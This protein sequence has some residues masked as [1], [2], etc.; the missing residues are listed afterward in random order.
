MKNE[1]VASENDWTGLTSYYRDE[2]GNRF[3]VGIHDLPKFQKESENAGR[4]VEKIPT[5]KYQDRQGNEFIVPEDRVRDFFYENAANKRDVAEVQEWE[6]KSGEQ[7]TI[8]LWKD[9]QAAQESMRKAGF[10][11]AQEWTAD[12]GYRF[13]DLS[14]AVRHAFSHAE[15]WGLVRNEDG[16]VDVADTA[17]EVGGRLGRGV[18][19]GAASIAEGLGFGL[20]KMPVYMAG[21]QGRALGSV[22]KLAGADDLADKLTGWQA[23]A[24]GALENAQEKTRNWV[25][26]NVLGEAITQGGGLGRD[27]AGA[28][29]GAGETYGDMRLALGALGRLGKAAI[30]MAFGAQA[31]EGTLEDPAIQQ[32]GA[33]GSAVAVV[34]GVANAL[35]M[36]AFGKLMHAYAL[37]GAA[38]EMQKTFGKALAIAFGE[39]VAA[40]LDMGAIE[41]ANQ[42]AR[43]IAGVEDTPVDGEGTTSVQ[44]QEMRTATNGE[45][46]GRAMSALLHGTIM[47]LGLKAAELSPRIAYSGRGMTRAVSFDVENA[48]REYAPKVTRVAEAARALQTHGEAIPK[49]PWFDDVNGVSTNGEVVFKDGTVY[50]PAKADRNVTV[51]GADGKPSIATVKGREARIVVSDGTILN[52]KGEVVGKL[53]GGQR[54]ARTV[55]TQAEAYARATD[56][57][58]SGNEITIFDRNTG[59]AA[60]I[61]A[62]ILDLAPDSYKAYNKWLLAGNTFKAPELDADG[63]AFGRIVGHFRMGGDAKHAAEMALGDV[64]NGRKTMREAADLLDQ[65]ERQMRG[66]GER[67]VPSTNSGDTADER[68]SGVVTPTNGEIK[69]ETTPRANGELPRETV[70]A[71]ADL[72]ELGKL[73]VIKTEDV[74]VT[75]IE[76]SPTDG[77]GVQDG[78]PV[79][80]TP[81]EHAPIVLRL[82]PETGRLEPVDGK[83]RIAA[84]KANGAKTVKA[85]V[86]HE[87]DG[88]TPEN[89]EAVKLVGNITSGN[90]DAKGMVDA[91]GK[92]GVDVDTAT[93]KGLIG[94]GGTVEQQLANN[95]KKAALNVAM[96]GDGQ[97]KAVVTDGNLM[98]ISDIVG[99]INKRT[100]GEGW[101]LAQR[102]AFY[103]LDGLDIT[104]RSRALEMMRT[105]QPFVQ[106]GEINWRELG[107]TAR[108]YAKH[109]EELKAEGISVS[110]LPGF[111]LVASKMSEDTLSRMPVETKDGKITTVGEVEAKQPHEKPDVP[112]VGSAFDPPEKLPGL[113]LQA[114]DGEL[115]VNVF[116]CSR[117]PDMKVSANG[118]MYSIEG[119]RPEDLMDPRNRNDYARVFGEIFEKAAEANEQLKA[120]WEKNGHRDANGQATEEPPKVL[121]NFPPQCEKQIGF[122]LDWY[123]HSV[124]V[125][126]KMQTRANAVLGILEKS[127]LASGVVKDQEAFDAALK[128]GGY[129][130][131]VADGLTYGWTDGTNVYLNPK[132]FGTRAGLNTPIHE[133]G[134]LGIIA[135]KKV[136]RALYDRGIELVKQTKE[137]KDINDPNG[138]YKDYQK[139]SDEKKA[140]EILTRF[141]AKG[142]EGIDAATPKGVVAEIKK[143]VAAFWESLGKRIGIRDLTPEQ[144]AKMATV[145]DVADAIRAEMMTGREFGTRELSLQE[146]DLKAK[147][148]RFAKYSKPTSKSAKAA[149][150]AAKKA[151]KELSEEQKVALGRYG[152]TSVLKTQEARTIANGV[153]MLREWD[154][155]RARISQAVKDQIR[156]SPNEGQK[157]IITGSPQYYV[158]QVT[159]DVTSPFA[160]AIDRGLPIPRKGDWGWDAWDRLT[161]GMKYPEKR[162]LMRILGGEHPKR[163]G[164]DTVL[165][166]YAQWL[167]ISWGEGARDFEHGRGI[168]DFLDDIMKERAKFEQWKSGDRKTREEYEA[169]RASTDDLAKVYDAIANGEPPMGLRPQNKKD[170]AI[171]MSKMAELSR[172]GKLPESV[173][174]FDTGANQK[175]Y[176]KFTYGDGSEFKIYGDAKSITAWAEKVGLRRTASVRQQESGM[177]DAEFAEEDAWVRASEARRVEAERMGE[178]DDLSDMPDFSRA[179]IGGAETAITEGYPLSI[180]EARDPN[181]VLPK[182]S[183][184]VGRSA[185]QIGELKL[186]RITEESLDHLLDSPSSRYQKNSNSKAGKKLWRGTVAGMTVVDD[187]VA[188]SSLGQQGLP[189]HLNREWKKKAKFYTADTRFAVELENGKY[190]VY[191]CK[192]IVSEI[193]GERIVYDLTEIGEPTLTASGSLKN[194]PLAPGVNATAGTPGSTRTAVSANPTPRSV[195]N[196]STNG[197][198]DIMLSRGGLYTGSAAD[199]EKPSL[200]KVGTGEGSQ[201]Y[202]WGLYASDRR[203]VAEEYANSERIKNANNNTNKI[204]AEVDKILRKK[205]KSQ[206]QIDDI[207]EAL[208]TTER[209]DDVKTNLI[210]GSFDEG[211]FDVFIKHEKEFKKI[212]DELVAHRNL[213]EQTFFTNRAPGDES[214]LLKWYEPVTREQMGW[215]RN[216]AE[217]EG[218]LDDRFKK[219]LD[220][221]EKRINGEVGDKANGESLYLHAKWALGTPQAASEF[222]ARAGIDG[223]KYPVDS[224]GKTVKDG[225]K[226]GWNYVSFRDDNIRVDHKWRDG[227]MLFSRPTGVD[228][229]LLVFG[230]TRVA[231]DA[232]RGEQTPGALAASRELS[233]QQRTPIQQAGQVRKLSLQLSD[234]EFARKFLTGSV[235]P[236]HIAKRLP[237]GAN[238]ASTKS[239]KLVIAADLFGI[240]DKT[241]HDVNKNFLK[242][243]GYFRNEDLGWC[244]GKTGMQIAAER[245]RS[246]EQLS[247]QLDALRQRRVNGQEPGGESAARAIFADELANI[248]M[249]MRHVPTGGTVG[250]VRTIGDGLRAGLLAR[251]TPDAI[252]D[253]AGAFLDWAYGAP[254]AGQTATRDLPAEQLTNRMFGAYLVMPNEIEARAPQWSREIND[255]IASDHKL[256]ETWR[257]LS[258]RA[259][260]EQSFGAVERQMLAALDR[261][262]EVLIRQMEAD[263]KK[264]ISAGSMKADAKEQL[265]VGFH[266]RMAPVAVRIDEKVKT[267]RA[268]KKE[269]MKLARTPQEKQRLASELSRFIG[270]VD[271]AVN[272][273]KLSRLAFERGASGEGM[274]YFIKEKLLL[275][276]L[277]ERQG[278]TLT[279]FALYLDHQRGIETQ[280]RANSG[281]M[282]PRQNKLALENMKLRLGSAKYHALEVGA[283]KWFAIH[284]QEFLDDPRL[285]KACG[286]EYVDYLKTQTHYV[287][288]A[289]TWSP[290]ELAGIEQGR[291]AARRSGVAGGDD[292]LESMFKFASRNGMGTGEGL[293][294]ARLTGSFADKKNVI[295]ATMDKVDRS[296]KFLRRN[297]YVM[298]LRDAL[299][300]AGVEGVRDVARGNNGFPTGQRYGHLNYLENGHKRTL[301]VPKQIAD[302]FIHD[303]SS[304][305]LYSKFYATWRKSI[306]DWNLAYW[307]RNIARNS[308]SI[309]KNMPGVRESYVKTALRPFGLGNFADTVC[310][311][312]VRHAPSASRLFGDDT[313]FGLIPKAKRIA[314]IRE[315]PS[316]WEQ[317]LWRAIDAGDVEA[318]ATLRGDLEELYR[319]LKTN[320]LAPVRGAYEGKDV[321]F[322]DDVLGQKSLKTIQRIRE[323]AANRTGGQKAL[324]AATWVFRRASQQQ[325]F[326]DDLAKITAYLHD[327]AKFG[328]VRTEKE[329]GLLVAE[330]V[331]IAQSER[332]GTLKRGIQGTI[333]T[334]YN[335]VEKGLVRNVK[336]HIARPGEMFAKDAKV[337][338]GTLVGGLLTT[339][340]ISWAIRKMFDDDES[341]IAESPFALPYQYAEFW[342]K[343]SKNRSTYMKENCNCV[344]VWMSPSGKTT[345]DIR[346]PY[347]DEDKL[348]VPGAQFAAEMIAA[349]CGI[350][351]EPSVMNMVK[352]STLNAITPDL[353][354]SG[355]L[356]MLLRDTVW[357]LFTNPEDYFT[358]RELYDKDLHENRFESLE[359]GGKFAA[360]MGLQLWNDL[361]GR[362]IY[363]PDRSGI[364]GERSEV[365]PYL[366]VVL[367]K[368]PIASPFVKSFLSVQTGDLDKY[369]KPLTEAEQKRASLL[370][371]LRKEAKKESTPEV[372]WFM[373]DSEGY[374]KQIDKWTETYKLTPDELEDLRNGISK[375]WLEMGPLESVNDIKKK[376]SIHDKARK[377]GIDPRYITD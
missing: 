244:A 368:L 294:T 232:G 132:Y 20:A 113:D 117:F 162:E 252:R 263:A 281:G 19:A 353:A 309:E 366:D 70:E 173:E 183:G 115:G 62:N 120:E 131:L 255:I 78:T 210:E 235:V 230:Q 253:E 10:K 271:D 212:H 331:S 301:I 99:K 310:Q 161:D 122:L 97:L 118:G 154:A 273:M 30:P 76:T 192:L 74:D 145:E 114:K 284:E 208:D 337:W 52:A 330:N 128:A 286:K 222:L 80:P 170:A 140:E 87:E 5:L 135:T 91:F 261:Q 328:G 204:Y 18:L 213:Y 110:G 290:E 47:T 247:N 270:S 259:M 25:I 332:S 188:T 75:Q 139:D 267:Y 130:E 150:E 300:A 100:W 37:K 257:Q 200:L 249:E 231:E 216:A 306:I 241:D 225:D 214:H 153:R 375:D 109:Y 22:A 207:Y 358:G 184:I 65:V 312:L 57:N 344:P 295:A 41:G 201:V 31:V 280:G 137:W 191:P 374:Q 362:V 23:G 14:N 355:P 279:D 163:G 39:S 307:N 40:G 4:K 141:I 264:P 343:A 69:V 197:K 359:M 243:N 77:A 121:V 305:R 317:Q 373:R 93:E 24:Y 342:R 172:D 349:K 339:G 315:D 35:G 248:V 174:A 63:L 302:G 164:M 318:E 86:L 49:G 221:A 299:L 56:P 377:Q 311:H 250:A 348:I 319:I 155:R 134:H 289:R 167:G 33:A 209:W 234:M 123:E 6:N 326:E 251:G 95:M 71:A 45:R 325:M 111:D 2:E 361:G 108:Y 269:A 333:A 28:G 55:D 327:R 151:W 82:N 360:A 38:K 262:T 178:Q 256:L 283:R 171:A 16:S 285:L 277:T 34:N 316:R 278:L 126:P 64:A 346:M 274:V 180:R 345:L 189:K 370:R 287:T 303:Q 11:P 168:E 96:W 313:I 298:D 169:E 61:P 98:A 186:T 365:S 8:T 203:G 297:Q 296:L 136:N 233:T 219:F 369:A 29:M 127:G 265:L 88:W 156:R 116:G 13:K 199:Y 44:Q 322:V 92:L 335:M 268:A 226:A 242:Q 83:K 138:P 26:D 124:K 144:I 32:A 356:W 1:V 143:W 103:E 293:L 363:Q 240:I 152:D 376:M 68:E 3:A 323:E 102:A 372:S 357:S 206:Q 27:L 160:Y 177:T 198:G 166:D 147:I 7:M 17:K 324:D 119:V 159:G 238:S 224:Y 190:E 215:V 266:D 125:D 211:S 292:V 148:L 217:K 129:Q 258:R 175:T 308:G 367:G 181:K 205:V 320:A 218:V 12:G 347:N 66:E 282:T 36:G 239:G 288:T 202:G 350:G 46:V 53:A 193:N 194:V 336:A 176:V 112:G 246:D 196:R 58:A 195:S 182:L 187:I 272:K 94:T 291:A 236:A 275:D 42:L 21:V 228:R 276:E 142:S 338:T 371:F 50:Y 329:T 60:D 352:R 9:S 51:T 104:S 15:D 223:V 149:L 165:S 72:H 107:E 67:D 90:L 334:F 105:V 304:M 364:E 89:A 245:K 354:L 59:R 341:K 254:A 340:V 54:L 101:E 84:E 133:F 79:K 185:A 179:M 260:S 229:S 158:S 73:D 321:G 146:G 220:V 351:A 106:S 314:M 43:G 227:E 48:R 237:G 85:V 81:T 157:K